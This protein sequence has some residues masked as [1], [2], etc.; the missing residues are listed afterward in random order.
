[1]SSLV[2][3][4]LSGQLN[5]TVG[6][7]LISAIVGSMLQGVTTC[8]TIIYF[9]RS[10]SDPLVVR[11]LVFFVWA[12]NVLHAILVA[13]SVY[14]SSVT[15]HGNP[16]ALATIPWSSMAIIIGNVVGDIGVKGIFS[17]RVWKISQQWYLGVLIMSTAVV[18]FC[19]HFFARKVSNAEHPLIH[20]VRFLVREMVAS[21]TSPPQPLGTYGSLASLAGSDILM[22]IVLAWVLYQHRS[23]FPSV[24]RVLRRLVLYSAETSLVTSVGSIVGLVIYAVLPDKPVLFMSILWVLPYFISSSVLLALNARKELRAKSRIFSSV[25][26]SDRVRNIDYGIAVSYDVDVDHAK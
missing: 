4:S 5:S 11:S 19:T 6:A 22:S 23:A 10:K 9:R 18:N 25:E 1:M 26:L 14:T 12:V 7:M 8:Q 20:S 24:N 13:D 17:Y 15:H 3:G 21:P 16:Y 2:G